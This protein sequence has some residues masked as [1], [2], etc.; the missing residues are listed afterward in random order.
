MRNELT[1]ETH[2][3]G[4]LTIEHYFLGG[5]YLD[6][7][8]RADVTING[9]R[10]CVFFSKKGAYYEMVTE[11]NTQQSRR[12]VYALSDVTEAIEAA[13][14]FIAKRTGVRAAG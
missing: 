2:Q 10:A 4:F 1:T 7:V 9:S 11:G 6:S 14:E 3:R 8:G 5:K 13:S 12:K